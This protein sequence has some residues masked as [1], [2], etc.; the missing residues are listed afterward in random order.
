M[1]DIIIYTYIVEADVDHIVRL[2]IRAVYNN[3][4]ELYWCDWYVRIYFA[5]IPNSSRPRRI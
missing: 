2:A 1:F 5:E 3:C 4:I